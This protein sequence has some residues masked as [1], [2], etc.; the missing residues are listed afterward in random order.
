MGRHSTASRADSVS[1]LP[2]V[3]VGIM[4]NPSLHLLILLCD[5]HSGTGLEGSCLALGWAKCFLDAV[6]HATDVASD[7]GNLYVFT[8]LD[9]VFVG[10]ASSSLL[11]VVPS[12]SEG[13]KV[14]LAGECLVCSKK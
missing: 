3:K 4:F 5:D 6:V 1:V 9:P 10:A 2:G 14:L 13:L 11:H 12:A 8:E 7:C